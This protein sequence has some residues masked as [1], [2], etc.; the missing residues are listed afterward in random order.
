MNKL[1][2][3]F[4]ASIP[5]A[6][7]PIFQIGDFTITNALFNSYI[8]VIFFIIIAIIAS[9]RKS[10][11]PKGIHNVFEA[12][13]EFAL[14][15]IEKVTGDRKLAK[16]FFPLVATIFF[17]ILFANWLGQIPG[18]GSI[19]VWGWLHGHFELIPILRP[20]SS[21]LNLTL[22]IAAVAI[23]TTHFV[24]MK[25]LG[26]INHVSKFFNIRGIFKSFKK[27]PIDIVVAIIEFFVGLIELIGE[28]AKTLSLSLRLFGN[29]FAGEV[30]I[31]VMLSLFS[32]F[33][34]IPFIFMELLVGVIQATVFAMLTLA[35]LTVSTMDHGHDDHEEHEG[36]TH[37]NQKT[38]APAH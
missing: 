7:E 11:V 6:A 9:R 15:E 36:D 22:G 20:A 8:S 35:F 25:K 3:R 26:V 17:F 23:L 29:I 21:D 16:A 12:I 1:N 31:H 28:F 37:Q 10:I 4:L 30:L 2:H 13:V 38:L 24:G 19:G 18:T 32:Y 34:P 14:K 5:L 33:L 27:K